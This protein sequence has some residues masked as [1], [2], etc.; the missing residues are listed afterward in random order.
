VDFQSSPEHRRA[1]WLPI[2][3]VVA[4]LVLVVIAGVIPHIGT[5]I[6]VAITAIVTLTAGAAGHA[7]GAAKALRESPPERSD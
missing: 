6:S 2:L 3:G 4:T 7:A 1:F 5:Q